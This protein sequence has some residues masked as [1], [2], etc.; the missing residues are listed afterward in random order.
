MADHVHNISFPKIFKMQIMVSGSIGYGGIDEIGWLYS[1]LLKEGFCIVD[2]LVSKGA[3]Y[4]DIKDFRDKKDLSHQ[5]VN[6]DL[7]YVKKADVLVVLANRP[8]YGTAI[9]MFIAKSIGKRVVLL[10]KDPLPTPWPI[11][12]A[13]DITTSEEELIKLLH[14]LEQTSK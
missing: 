5:I 8:S 14:S 1:F 7:E 11:N 4:S 9:E 12:F 10:A 6:H 3:D 2:H 13:D